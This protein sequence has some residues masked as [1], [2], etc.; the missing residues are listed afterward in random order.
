[1]HI[2]KKDLRKALLWPLLALV[3]CMLGWTAL[4]AQLAREKSQAEQEALR[5][6]EILARAYGT[7]L[8]R[9][10]EAVDQITRYVKYGWEATG[11]EFTLEQMGQQGLFGRHSGFYISLIDERGNL[12]SST[13]P[14]AQRVNIVD[15][16]YFT[17]HRQ[18]GNAFHIGV[19][20]IGNFSQTPVVPFSRRLTDAQG[21][22]RGI[23]L[24]SVIPE[25]FM[26]NYDEIALGR[27]GFLALL[28]TDGVA[29]L[30]RVGNKVFL[31]R[32]GDKALN[33]Q[34]ALDMRAGSRLF[35]AQDSFSDR[36]PRYVAWQTTSGYEMVTMA[37]FDQEDI[38]GPYRAKRRDWLRS[39]ALATI[40]LAVA[41]AAGAFVSLRLTRERR[42]FESMQATYRTATEGGSDGFFIARPVCGR[43]GEVTD[44]TIIDCNERGAEFLRHRR[45]ELIGERLKALYRGEAAERAMRMMCKAM[46]VRAYEGEA[47]LEALGVSGPK[48]AHFRV[49]R[50]DNDL[51]VTMRD[52]SGLKAHVAEL[53]RRGN[54]DAL[55][56]LPNRHWANAYL[57]EAIARA[58][59]GGRMIALLFLDLDGFKTVNDTAGHQA[60]DD[61]LRHVGRRLREAVRPNDQ[62]A[63]VG[64]DEFLVILQKLATAAD[65]AHVAQRILDAFQPAFKIGQTSYAVGVSI[66]IGMFPQDGADANT[67]LKN[68]D[69]AMYS[70]KTAGKHNYRFF[71]PRFSEILR[72]RHEREA[73]LRQALENDQLVMYYQPRV[74]LRTGKTCSMEALVRW[75]H[76]S[77]GIVGPGEFIALAEETGLILTLGEQV[78]H[79]VCAQIAQW[80]QQSQA[81]VPVSINVSA[82]QFQETDVAALVAS[83]IERYRIDP[84]FIEIELTESSMIGDTEDVGQALRALQRL[85]VKLLV[86]DFGTGYSSLSQLQRLDFDVLKVDRAFTAE[87]DKTREGAVF[88]SAIITM[89]HALGMRV[90]AE[91][92]ETQDQVSKLKA[93]HCDEVQGFFISR[94]LPSWQTPDIAPERFLSSTA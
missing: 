51:A 29:R 8:F 35:G 92:V 38:L 88:F 53:E 59:D 7:H 75:Q 14:G 64:G 50:P 77:K 2:A 1:M 13:I 40:L 28:G 5:D 62:V 23:V 47:D 72:S 4:L 94:P 36:R 41:A 45:E 82:R 19:A 25:Y 91:G 11:G 24:V 27:H 73:E 22:F 21:R 46:K 31:P 12:I 80:Q 78:I 58:R 18:A 15:E 39:A 26:S 86:D 42:Q 32:S 30:E 68:A 57:P 69:I 33:M 6:A 76:P 93:L 16:P 79:K 85:G 17:V 49:C 56:Q 55:T 83:C 10:L 65:A 81:L 3:V 84:R 67:L 61:I 89:A 63:R 74:E 48:W 52:I 9:A 44:F 87:L 20:R 60:G 54:E 66:G 90:V 43:D 34:P 37:G 71:D 70:A